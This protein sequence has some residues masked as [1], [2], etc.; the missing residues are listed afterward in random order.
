MPFEDAIGPEKILQ[1]Y[2]PI[3]KMQGVVVIDNTALGPG[4]GGI[5]MVPDITTEEVFGLARAMTWKNALADIPFGGAKSGIKA[6]ASN[7]HKA[8]LVAA[9]A[10][11]IAELVPKTYIPGPDMNM[12]EGDMKIIAETIGTPKAATGK[13]ASM[14]GLPHE[15][16][17]TGYGVALSTQV[18]LEHAKIPIEGATVAIEGFGN[19]GTFTAKHL[20][21]WGA[22]IVAVSDS[23][24]AAYLEGGLDFE[25][26]MRVKKEKG[27]VAAYPGAKVL[28]AREL[29]SVKC[30]VLIPGARP[31]VI[32]A[33]NMHSI[34]AKIIVEAANIPMRHE[35]EQQLAK[36]GILI[37]PDFVANAGGVISSYVEF[38]G[39]S[40]KE[41]FSMVKEKITANTRLVL[42]KA[43]NG[44]LRAAALA[45][46][47]ERVIDAME[48][49]RNSKPPR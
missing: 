15:L 48:R 39:G 23:K 31:D 4:K 7:S 33:G 43:K 22:K 12:G 16:G 42:E 41:M 36:R 20:S 21:S 24:G 17:S 34:K 6:S 44:D 3:T 27:T 1:V 29:F 18:A 2:D 45:I 14:G 9:F 49:R 13:P 26:L 35:I 28:E 19:V 32:H 46:A 47:E 40:E 8:Q 37:I 5:R 11:K 10:E 30:D 25:T 38:I